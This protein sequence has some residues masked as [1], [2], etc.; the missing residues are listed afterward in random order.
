MDAMCI[1]EDMLQGK[2][3]AARVMGGEGSDSKSVG[4]SGES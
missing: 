1:S 2:L 4:G 3:N